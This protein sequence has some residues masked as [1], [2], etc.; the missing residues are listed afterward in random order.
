MSKSKSC[1]SGCSH[2]LIGLEKLTKEVMGQNQ[3][4]QNTKQQERITIGHFILTDFV[5]HHSKDLNITTPKQCCW[6]SLWTDDAQLPSH[7]RIISIKF[8][9]RGFIKNAFS[10]PLQNCSLQHWCRI[11]ESLI[12]SSSC[13]RKARHSKRLSHLVQHVCPHHCFL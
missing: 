13:D 8:Y 6:R 5:I 7:Q 1:W 4:L 10:V 12:L 9:V 3:K 2:N 11:T